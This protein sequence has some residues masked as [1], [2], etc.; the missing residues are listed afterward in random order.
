MPDP[1]P[2][3]TATCYAARTLDMRLRL[4]LPAALL[5]VLSTWAVGC[6]NARQLSSQ[7]GHSHTA[8]SF[9]LRDTLTQEQERAIGIAKQTL[10][11]LTR[12]VKPPPGLVGSGTDIFAKDVPDGWNIVFWEGWGDCLAG[13]INGRMCYVSVDTSGAVT[14]VGQFKREYDNGINAYRDS[15]VA[16]WDL[17]R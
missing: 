16:I 14:L 17:T 5:T 6:S 3:R 10:P 13:C 2:E 1:S 15:G 4:A 9:N 12:F 7:D 11:W 8:S